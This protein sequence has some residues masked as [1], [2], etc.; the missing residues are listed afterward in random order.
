MAPD[1]EWFRSFCKDNAS[2]LETNDRLELF[3]D[4]GVEDFLLHP[5][6]MIMQAALA[7]KIDFLGLTELR[8]QNQYFASGHC[9]C[10]VNIASTHNRSFAGSP[11]PSQDFE[12]RWIV[13]KIRLVHVGLEMKDLLKK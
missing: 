3:A 9:G 4:N 7:L 5:S 1:R 13:E 12:R 6:K 2:I 10:K 11:W 8:H